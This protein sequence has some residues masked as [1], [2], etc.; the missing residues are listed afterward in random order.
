MF[1]KIQ[2]TIKISDFTKANELIERILSKSQENG[3][4]LLVVDILLSKIEIC[5]RV[6]N[7]DEGLQ[8]VSEVEELFIKFCSSKLCISV[9]TIFHRIEHFYVAQVLILLIKQPDFQ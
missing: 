7:L 5:W 8:I 6:G 1:L 2:L 9:N 3:D 4:E